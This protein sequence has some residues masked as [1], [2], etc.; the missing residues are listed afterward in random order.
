MCDE[1]ARGMEM[2]AAPSP[3]EG[4]GVSVWEEAWGQVMTGELSQ[5]GRQEASV[6][7]CRRG[8]TLSV[9]WRRAVRRRQHDNGSVTRGSE[10]AAVSGTR[11]WQVW[12][13]TEAKRMLAEGDVCVMCVWI[14]F[15]GMAGRSRDTRGGDVQSVSRKAVCLPP[16]A[17][18]VRSA[19]IPKGRRVC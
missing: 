11:A 15:S 13:S 18:G 5:W 6:S 12:H 10:R 7:S 14:R 1:R 2:G 16:S 19:R 17:Y 9:S 4:G 3:E 8:A